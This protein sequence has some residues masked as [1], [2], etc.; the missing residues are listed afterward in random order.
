MHKS[1]IL[2]DDN[3]IQPTMQV[4]SVTVTW[5]SLQIFVPNFRSKSYHSAAWS[6]RKFT[7]F[8]P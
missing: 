8:F 7:R 6:A 3:A 5:L 2:F 1:K 4:K